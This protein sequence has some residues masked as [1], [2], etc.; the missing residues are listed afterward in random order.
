MYNG[1]KD[2][3]GKYD[4]PIQN[5][6]KEGYSYKVTTKGT[7]VTAAEEI[8]SGEDVFTPVVKGEPGKTTLANFLRTALMPVGTTL[9]IYGGGWDWQDV[10]SSI[11]S[12]T[13]GVSPDWVRFFKEHDENFTFKG[14]DGDE[15]N[16]DPATSYYP[17]GKYNEYYYAGLFSWDTSDNGAGLTDPEGIQDMSPEEAL[18][19]LFEK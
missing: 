5:V 3:E 9:Y 6:L 18:A 12:R 16:V 17:F 8:V 13:I 7:T 4:Y 14:K 10:G 2:A 15:E 19:L 1:T 11:Q